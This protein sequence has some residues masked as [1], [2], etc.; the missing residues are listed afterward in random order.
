MGHMAIDNLSGEQFGHLPIFHGTDAT[1][2]VGDVVKPAKQVGFKKHRSDGS[3]AW[4]SENA[5][6]A[7]TYGKNVYRVS[8]LEDPSMTIHNRSHPR[9]YGSTVG[10]KVVGPQ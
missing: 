6:E 7:K 9:T 1:L 2:K 10:F 8:H 5:E 4:A 3:S